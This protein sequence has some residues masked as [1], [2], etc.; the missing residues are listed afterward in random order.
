ME[1]ETSWARLGLNTSGRRVLTKCLAISCRGLAFVVLG[2]VALRGLRALVFLGGNY[3]SRP[4][5]ESQGHPA[6]RF[7]FSLLFSATFSLPSPVWPPSD[8]D[9]WAGGREEAGK[10][11]WE[12]QLSEPGLTRSYDLSSSED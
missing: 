8:E 7:P 11:W 12:S 6:I 9:V 4:S 5:K 3:S 1:A 2:V 10:C